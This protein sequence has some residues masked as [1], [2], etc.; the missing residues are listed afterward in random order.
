MTWIIIVKQRRTKE[1]ERDKQRNKET[2]K[3]STEQIV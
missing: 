1:K 3:G 2:K